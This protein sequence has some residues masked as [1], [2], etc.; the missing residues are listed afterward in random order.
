MTSISLKDN[1]IVDKL[2]LGDYSGAIEAL[3]D[4]WSGPGNIPD[5]NGFEPNEHAALVMVCGILTVEQGLTGGHLQEQGKN[6]LS[7]SVRLFGDDVAGAQMARTWLAIAYVRCGDFNESLV[8]CDYLLS[9]KDSDLEVTV[10]AAKTKSI[11]L[12]GL[13]Y[14]G[15]ALEILDDIAGAVE[16]LGPLNQGK[17]LLQR[18]TV[19]RKLGRLDEAVENYDLAI[20]KFYKAKSPRY[21]ASAANNIAGIYMDR[22][23]YLRAHILTEKAIRLFREINDHVHEGAVWDQSAQI[24][25]K[26]GKLCE[27]E[28]SAR[29]AITLLEQ[30]D[31]L[32][33]LAEAYTTLGT[34]LVDIGVGAA[35]PLGKAATIYRETGNIILLDSVNALLWDNVVRI[36]RMAKE[37]SQAIHA[38]VRP[39]EHKILERTLE[40]HDWSRSPTAKELGLTR[41]GLRVML[42]N[43]YP[44][45]LAKCDPII[46]RRRSVMTKEV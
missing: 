36:K 2:S 39:L 25:R 24:S 11:A 5:L 30:T 45:L 37:H 18:G 15:K 21:E 42:E 28:K 22:K 26:E 34:V 38:A 27:A 41:R 44:D 46:P 13:G 3:G 9:S 4:H 19:L 10:A 32:D 12:D 23:D 43:H 1:R 29:K 16:A 8:L 20:E 17:V 14:P 31:R 35:E 7:Q 40:K 6:M 33:Y